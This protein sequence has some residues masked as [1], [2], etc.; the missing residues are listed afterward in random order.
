MGIMKTLESDAASDQNK[1]FVF[2]VRL[3][4]QSI[5]KDY[6]PVVKNDPNHVG[7]SFVNGEATVRLTKDQRASADSLPTGLGYTVVEED[8]ADYNDEMSVSRAMR[9]VTPKGTM[10]KTEMVNAFST[11]GRANNV[12]RV[13][14][15]VVSKRLFNARP[16]D[17]D[18]EFDF[19]VAEG[20][21]E[22]S[23]TIENVPEGTYT[24]TEANP[25]KKYEFTTTYK[26][27]GSQA[28]NGKATVVVES[29]K[30]SAVD[31]TNTFKPDKP[32]F[33]KKIKD[34]NDTTGETSNWQDSAD[35]DIGDAVPYKL[36]ATLA[37]D[38]TA[39]K[40][41]HITFTDKMEKSLT[42]KKDARIVVTGNDGKEID[43]SNTRWTRSPKRT[44]NSPTK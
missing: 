9:P 38:V 12:R 27:D 31:I 26:V 36:T 14:G 33:D 10:S 40:S 8:A 28:T 1:V 44:T 18:Q 3:S 32:S 30:T 25:P 19:K 24:V 16:E 15:L 4:D 13:G 11:S 20:E 21:T 22:P 23:W 35:Y 29:G 43:A 34:T 41:Y 5:T 37:K 39:Y 2:T 17:Y 7:I 6:E 42:Y